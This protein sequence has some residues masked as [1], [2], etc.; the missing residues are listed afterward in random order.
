MVGPFITSLTLLCGFA[1]AAIESAPLSLP[2]PSRLLVDL[3][4]RQE[5]PLVLVASTTPSF[6]FVVPNAGLPNGIEMTAFEVVVTDSKGHQVW[7]SG[8]QKSKTAANIPYGGDR[9]LS[10]GD[11]YSWTAR[12]WAEGHARDPSPLAHSSFEVVLQDTDWSKSPWLGGGVQNE[13]LLSLSNLPAKHRAL[14]S[15]VSASVRL[16]LASPGGATVE[17]GGKAI[18]GDNVGIHMWHDFSKSVSYM[19]FDVSSFFLTSSASTQ[20]LIITCGR[21]FW[22][23]HQAHGVGKATAARIMLVVRDE[24]T[25]ERLVVDSSSIQGRSSAVLSDDPWEGST[26]QVGREAAWSA[27]TVLTPQ[28]IRAGYAPTGKL[29]PLPSPYATTREEIK[30]SSVEPV[31]GRPGTF[32]YTFPRNLVGHASVTAGAF[33]GTGNVTL[34]H[35]ETWDHEKAGCV[36]F[37]LIPKSANYTQLRCGLNGCDQYNLHDRSSMKRLSPKFTWHGFQ[38][39]VVA[40]GAGLAFSGKLDAL[41][42]HWTTASLEESATIEFGGSGSGLLGQIRDITKASQI[43][44]M[45]AYTPTDCPTRE[46]HGW[47]GDSQP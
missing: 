37:G 4:E 12:W 28:Q 41:S 47:L 38:H 35:C 20:D 17:A 18:A 36:P 27:A 3:M 43:S 34:E 26:L 46:K 10:S 30:P 15:S 32:L 44:N 13:Y 1:T 7:N 19:T 23:S 9:P 40:P 21:G 25:G 11:T 2:A 39:V 16:Y 33:Q 45:A 5:P 29:V 24:S 22:M 8:K 14:L 6:S 31:P 42:A